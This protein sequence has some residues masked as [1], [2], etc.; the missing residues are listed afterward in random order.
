MEVHMDLVT[1]LLASDDSSGNAAAILIG[2]LYVAA[3]VGFIWWAIWQAQSGSMAFDAPKAPRDVIVD[4]MHHFSTH[5][6]VTTTQT[7]DSPTMTFTRLQAPGCAITL[8]LLIFGIIPGL[9][10]WIAA[11]RTLAVSISATPSSGT[12]GYSTVRMSWSRNGGGRGPSLAF[13]RLVAPNQPLLTAQSYTP[14]V[15]ANTVEDVSGGALSAAAMRH[16]PQAAAQALPPGFC[17]KC[18]A[19]RTPPEA[20]FCGACGS[21]F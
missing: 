6:W 16:E 14:N 19:Q 4:A 1:L 12:P 17:A 13:K 3:I 18:G 7:V 15:L 2:L 10:Y 21:A 8:V 11:K 20:A 5:G 9:L